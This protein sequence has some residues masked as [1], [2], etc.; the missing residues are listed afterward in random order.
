MVNER[1][2]PFEIVTVSDFLFYYQRVETNIIQLIVIP[3]CGTGTVVNDKVHWSLIFGQI[4]QVD[5]YYEI[6]LYKSSD[7][8][9]YFDFSEAKD[10]FYTK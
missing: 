2:G 4:I 9:K 1:Y 7:E 5:S 8:Q 6:V 10:K 3:F